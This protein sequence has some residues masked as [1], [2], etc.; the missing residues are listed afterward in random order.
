MRKHDTVLRFCLAAAVA[1]IAGAGS[2]SAAD[3]KIA[4]QSV[5]YPLHYFAGRLAT[6]AF[7]VQY[8]VPGDVDPAFWKPDDDAVV[9]FQEADVILRNGADYAKWMKSVTLPATTMVDTSKAFSE[10]LIEEEGDRHKH[11][12]GDVHSHG[13]TAFTTWLDFSQAIEQARAVAEKFKQLSSD[14]AEAIDGKFAALRKDLESLDADMEKFGD[15]WGD[16]PLTASHPIYQYSARAYGL[17]IEALEWEP[18]MEFTAEAKRDLQKLLGEHPAKWMIWEGEPTD[19]LVEGIAE[20]GVKSVVV[21]P[22]ANRPDAGDWLVV[23]K[24]NLKNLHAML[25]AVPE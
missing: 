23:M 10:K 8:I 19:E 20:L 7:D 17:K 4:V 11:G 16:K 6:D 15:E 9:A 3:E 1:L 12:D 24:Q 25:E 21:D 22:C 14:D 2:S 18:E 13:G 5:N